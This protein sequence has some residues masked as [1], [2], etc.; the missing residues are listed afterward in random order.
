[1][2]VFK[3]LII[4]II[5]DGVKLFLGQVIFIAKIIVGNEAF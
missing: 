2:T 1:M 4:N 3:L 5:K